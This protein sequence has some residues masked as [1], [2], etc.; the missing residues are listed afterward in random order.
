[1]NDLFTVAKDL[2]CSDIDP[3]HF[4]C[5]G[6]EIVGDITKIIEDFNNS[7]VDYIAAGTDLGDILYALL[8]AVVEKKEL[9]VQSAHISNRLNK[10]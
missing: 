10:E 4:V 3:V 5:Q 1:V 2:A 7:P 6:V 8:T 9:V